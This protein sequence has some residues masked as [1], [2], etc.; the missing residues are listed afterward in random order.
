MRYVI[1]SIMLLFLTSCSLKKFYPLGGAIAGGS[2]GSLGGPVSGGLGAGAGW[3]AGEI[4]KG[5]AEL[6]E[7]KKTIEALTHG[8]VEKLLA[9]EMEGQKSILQKIEDGI[10][11]TIKIVGLII[12]L[13]VGGTIFYT[14]L[15][16]K[17][18]LEM[19]GII[20]EDVDRVQRH[21]K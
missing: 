2:A 3:A 11:N 21:S 10:W 17:K 9:Q 5:D 4:A 14:R 15:K 20:N 12:L 18:T 16:C 8:D 6:T 1:Y 13:L 19:L 7:A